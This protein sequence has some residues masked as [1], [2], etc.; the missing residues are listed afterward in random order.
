MADDQLFNR[1]GR[2]LPA[3][4]VLFREGEFGNQMFVIQSGS[5]RITKIVRDTEKL[6]AILPAGEFFGEMAILNNKPRSANAIVHED[7]RLLVIEAKTFEGMIR[8]NTEIALRLIKKL[9]QR[10]S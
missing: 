6:L 10:L 3:G 2:D 8:G 9:A 1:F 5:V 7:A 4:T